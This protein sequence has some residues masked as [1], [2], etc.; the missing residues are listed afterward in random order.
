MRTR[1][2]GVS[3]AEDRNCWRAFVSV[4]PALAVEIC[5]SLLLRSAASDQMAGRAKQA[6]AFR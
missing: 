4:E 1:S 2:A 6:F 3:S 5:A